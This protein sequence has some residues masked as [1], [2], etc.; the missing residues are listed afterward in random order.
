MNLDYN[1]DSKMLLW[2]K[3]RMKH[4][5]GSNRDKDSSAAL[6]WAHPDFRPVLG[7]QLPFYWL[8]HDLIVL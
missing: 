2:E 8:S 5:I 4:L 3:D 1:I 6:L 7:E